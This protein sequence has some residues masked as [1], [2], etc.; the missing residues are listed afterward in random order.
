MISCG[1]LAVALQARRLQKRVH[2]LQMQV[3]TDTSA[4]LA[5]QT[6]SKRAETFKD[7]GVR[8]EVHIDNPVTVAQGESPIAGVIGSVAPSLVH[9]RVFQEVQKQL[10]E[11]LSLRGV[12]AR[13][14]VV[15][16]PASVAGSEVKS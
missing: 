2:Q 15:G 11:E 13:V 12:A 6:A 9:K 4:P 16:L 7:E 1:L 3:A 14:R 5:V 10:A 8:L